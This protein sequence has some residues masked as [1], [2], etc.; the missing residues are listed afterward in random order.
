V[1]NI[2]QNLDRVQEL[3]RK[4]ALK[5][6]RDP[7]TIRLLAVSKT[8][9]A[10]VVDRAARAGQRSFGENRIQ[11][12][13][14][15]IPAVETEGL[16][17]HLVGH[18]QSNKARKA[19]EIFDVIETIDSLKIARR[20]SRCCEELKKEIEVLI[21]VNI[22]GERQKSGFAPSEV[23][24]AVKEVEKLPVLR[25]TGLMT[26][27]PLASEPEESRPFFKRMSSLLEEINA[28]QSV[29]LTELSMG[30]SGDYLVAIE[31]GAT[32][33]RLGTSIFGPRG[34]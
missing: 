7:A 25:L 8:F 5:C 6:G 32:I 29:H 22:G 20:I 24:A 27:P 30:M 13:I 33:V 23:M 10:S 34:Q 12:A 3:L 19:V 9:P 1:T 17:W 21:Q 15:K 28:G 4:T 26:I 11:E 18:L 14:S 2:V 16:E 31:E